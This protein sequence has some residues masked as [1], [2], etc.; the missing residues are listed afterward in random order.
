MPTLLV[1]SQFQSMYIPLGAGYTEKQ[2]LTKTAIPYQVPASERTLCKV[3]RCPNSGLHHS[4][5]RK[6]PSTKRKLKFVKHVF[7]ILEKKKGFLLMVSKCRLK[8]RLWRLTTRVCK[9]NV[10]CRTKLH[11]FEN[12]TNDYKTSY[13]R[14][15]T[16][17]ETVWNTAK[18]LVE[19]Q[20][21]RKLEEKALAF[22]LTS[23]EQV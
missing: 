14:W 19:E 15:V 21:H 20:K 23:P 8:T 16:S 11:F 5:S 18:H 17:V 1:S 6:L 22:N 9:Q 4:L 12:Q 13:Q 7:K 3:T 2:P 10:S